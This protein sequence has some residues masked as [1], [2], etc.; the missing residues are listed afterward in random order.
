[1]H[2]AVFTHLYLTEAGQ[3]SRSVVVGDTTTIG[4]DITN[5]IVLEAAT[6]SRYH[7]LLLSDAD[8]LLLIDLE[9][10]NGTFVNGAPIQPDEPV[11]LA[12]GDV[13]QV[14]EVVARYAAA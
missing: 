4:R 14:G 1:M 12:D 11:R 10:T 3:P 9:S 7:A 13:I 6:V 8:G 5:D 2:M